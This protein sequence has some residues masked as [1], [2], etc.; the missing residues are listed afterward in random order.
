M[1]KLADA[2]LRAGDKTPAQPSKVPTLISIR[3]IIGFINF[4]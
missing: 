1:K 3:I 2:D 4:L